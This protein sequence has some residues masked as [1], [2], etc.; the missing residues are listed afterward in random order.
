M[1]SRFL[2]IHCQDLLANRTY[3]TSVIRLIIDA[4]S[5]LYDDQ[6]F[7]AISHKHFL[8]RVSAS[9][10]SVLNSVRKLLIWPSSLTLSLCLMGKALFGAI[11][12]VYGSLM[13][14]IAGFLVGVT[15]DQE[16][17]ERHAS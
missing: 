11:E 17:R 2:S 16:L 10:G 13:R 6:D 9:S 4:H 5:S 3:A 15:L 8:P 7:D 12:G 1:V 14:S